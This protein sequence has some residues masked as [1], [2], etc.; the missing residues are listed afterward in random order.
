MS[1]RRYLPLAVFLLVAAIGGF[2]TYMVRYNEN[3]ALSA[4]FEVVADEA[5]DRVRDRVQQ[6]IALLIAAV[7]HFD[8]VGRIDDRAGFAKFV[9]KLDLEGRYKG[10]QGIGF[11]DIV[12]PGG[13]EDFRRN[14]FDAYG[15]SKTPWPESTQPVRTGILLLEPFNQRNLAA[16]GFDMYSEEKRRDA[17]M[18]ALE[19]GEAAATAPVTLVQE[20]TED[21]QSGFL[22]YLP[23]RSGSSATIEGFVYAPFRAGDLHE[24][25]LGV[26]I[27]PVEL[28]TRDAGDQAA[29]VLFTSAGFRS[30]SDHRFAVFR[31]IEIGG[32]V[33]RMELHDTPEFRQGSPMPYALITG[34]ISILLAAAMAAATRW[35]MQAVDAAHSLVALKEESLLEKDLLLQEMK[36]RIK[37]SIARILAMA[38]QTASSSETIEDFSQSFSARLQSMANAQDMLT[39]SHWQGTDLRELLMTELQQVYGTGLEDISVTGDPVALNGKQTQALGL[40]FHELATNALKY[41]A[42]T[43]GGKLDISW[44][45]TGK[46]KRMLVFE[47]NEFGGAGG[48][49]KDHKGF[50]TRLIDAS[51]KGELQG[52][53]DRNFAQDGLK[54]R[55]SLPL[56]D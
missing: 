56:G 19:T 33:W 20:I 54:I 42:G 40:T 3:V 22:V 24:A 55:I 12:K 49:G 47:W 31:E 51:I 1:V 34:L 29:P 39:R 18:R 14:L 10:V 9:A 6:H 45:T 17:M 53:I 26:R 7:G 46:R 15:V 8:A 52:E 11:A 2:I 38:R 50:G 23:L 27:L 21:K 41:G 35:Q 44:K 5:A 30:D 48:S 32:R 36:H 43:D 16:L 25:A 4:R 28:Q 37:N 13:D